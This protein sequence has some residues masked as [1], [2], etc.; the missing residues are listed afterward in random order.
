MVGWVLR[1]IRAM[2]RAIAD[3]LGLIPKDHPEI[4]HHNFDPPTQRRWLPHFVTLRGIIGMEFKG[5]CT[6]DGFYQ[7]SFV[8]GA[9]SLGEPR[10]RALQ[11]GANCSSD[12]ATAAIFLLSLQCDSLLHTVELG[13]QNSQFRQCFWNA[14]HYLAS[15]WS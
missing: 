5:H 15:H 4:C 2:Q 9:I 13:E 8:H 6:D 1:Q 12:W 7:I 10:T 3:V 14:L 11:S